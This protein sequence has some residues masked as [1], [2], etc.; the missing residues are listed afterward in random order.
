[1][2]SPTKRRRKLERTREDRRISYHRKVF[3]PLVSL[4]QFNNTKTQGHWIS[5]SASFG[6]EPPYVSWCSPF[7]FN[8]EMRAVDVFLRCAAMRECMCV[9]LC[10][11]GWN[12]LQAY[13]PRT[14]LRM[15]F[16]NCFPFRNQLVLE[17]PLYCTFPAFSSFSLFRIRFF[18]WHEFLTLLCKLVAAL[19]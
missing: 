15:H 2:W 11:C 4:I 19:Y 13:T 7:H 3:K 12:M 17:F 6:T 9:C 18:S 1:M 8:R 10:S 16:R 14:I 5:F